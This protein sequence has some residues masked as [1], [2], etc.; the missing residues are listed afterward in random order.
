MRGPL[1]L[2]FWNG[3]GLFVLP[4]LCL[5][6]KSRKHILGLTYPQPGCI[7]VHGASAGEHQAARAICSHLDMP[8]WRTYSTW[9][10]PI[11][12]AF[13]APLDIPFIRKKWFKNARPQMLILIEAELWPGW[14]H[15][16]RQ[17]NIPVVIVNARPSD[18]MARWKGFGLWSW[19][20]KDVKFFTVSD[21]GDLK[22]AAIVP[23]PKVIFPQ[24]YFIAA[25]TH[26]G[27]EEMLL[28]AW[29]KL[30]SP[31][32]LI[33]GPRQIHRS[34]EII[35]ICRNF[36]CQLRSTFP[37][38]ANVQ[39]VVLDTMGEMASLF[40]DASGAFIGGTFTPSV[41]GHSPAEAMAV[42]TP[43]VYGPETKSN[44]ETF[45][46]SSG[47]QITNPDNLSQAISDCLKQSPT[48]I[49]CD[50]TAIVRE[51][52]LGNCP[53]EE[54]KRPILKPFTHLWTYWGRRQAN[55]SDSPERS[56]IP[57]ISVGALSAGGTAKTPIS[58]WITEQIPSAWVSS[59]GYRRPKKGSFIRTEHDLGDEAEMLRRGGL[60][61]ISCP[62]RLVAAQYASE[63]GARAL[64]IDDGFQ[65]KRLYRNLNICCLN[66][67][68]PSSR[69]II[70]NGWAREGWAAL[71]RASILW[72]HNS[73]PYLPHPPLPNTP[74]VY[75]RLIPS[76]WLHKGESFPLSH[77]KGHIN[78]AVGI[79]HP[80]SFIT[81]LHQ[82]GL[83]ISTLIR[84][85]DHASLPTL[86]SGCVITEKDA[87]RLPPNSNV[88]VLCMKLQIDN[89]EFIEEQIRLCLLSHC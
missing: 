32:L 50:V 29:E 24:P 69:G 36:S 38:K 49:Q 70:P 41:G 43:F 47:I 26:A 65:Y 78:V 60:K 3:V 83:H 22:T 46:L 45:E 81:T 80:A 1:F 68:W 35:E 37:L 79:A 64:V 76:H 23:P 75:S 57:I 9:R 86:T 4:I 15:E 8:F 7:W 73:E 82:L 58:R 77:I 51:L 89:P 55:Y 10:T 40:K 71:E 18:S 5:F 34:I 61:V 85:A 13:P 25:S 21:F 16:C 31:P 66:M 6:S 28:S 39:I 88:W 84:V 11:P 14:V 20:T 53:I 74:K 56:P 44:K 72:L 59:R 19:L 2:L 17:L 54:D 48:Q 87:A 30:S 52:P 42:G 12:D 33:I 63:N 67:Q 62:D 27:E